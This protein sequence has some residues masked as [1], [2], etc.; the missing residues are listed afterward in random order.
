MPEP[1]GWEFYKAYYFKAAEE[2]LRKVSPLKTL[3]LL[4]EEGEILI[5]NRVP[6]R[7]AFERREPLS[8]AKRW[9]PVLKNTA[10]I[11]VE[12]LILKTACD[13]RPGL[14]VLDLMP[15]ES[16][17]PGLIISGRGLKLPEGTLKLASNV[18]FLP[19]FLKKSSWFLK[20]NWRAGKRFAAATVSLKSSPNL[21]EP[22]ARLSF[23]KLFGLTYLSPKA[24]TRLQPFLEN[25]QALKRVLRG[26]RKLILVKR[27]RPHEGHKGLALGEYLLL[28]TTKK[29]EDLLK[30]SERLCVGLY[31]GGF[32]GPPLGLVYAACEHAQRVGGGLVSFEPFSYHVL[33]DL[34]A[35]WGDLGAALW[36]Y[37]LAE[38]GTQ[39]PGD[40]FNSQ[41]LIL[42]A[43]ELYE[44]AEKAFRK[45]LSFAP[46]DPLINFNL[47][48][49]LLEKEDPEALKYLRLA[50]KVSS[51]RSLFAETLAEALVRANQKEK[52]LNLLLGR[53]DLS[54]KGQALLGRLLY[55]TGKFEEAFQ[56]LKEVSLKREAPAEALAYLALLYKSKGESEAALVLAREALRRGGSRISKILR[57]A[58]EL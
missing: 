6:A 42:K 43:L 17:V 37:R 21:K 18:Y 14:G 35:D 15:Q 5:F 54:L 50:L 10:R 41:G 25:F 46:E 36:A 31:K 1:Q 34:Y 40:L 52:A 45:A 20:E 32:E 57:Q 56:C 33:G 24:E 13:G 2:E 19:S 26:K 28:E 8:E 38:K 55:E 27:P 44:E 53:K 4:P 23:A 48:S 30:T 47:G 49:L 58:E 51:E 29:A 12:N 9:L 7:L 22:Q 39:Q 16:P 3:R 11:L